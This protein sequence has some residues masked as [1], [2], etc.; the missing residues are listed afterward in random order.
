MLDC[1]KYYALED[2]RAFL[3]PITMADKEN[4][5]SFSIHEPKLWKYSLVQ[6]IG[7]N[8]LHEYLE[9]TIKAKKQGKEYAFIVFDKQ[10]NSY[11]GS[12]R[13]YD[14]QNENLTLQLGYTWY[15][16]AYHGTGLNLHCKYLL[17]SFAFEDLGM[18]RVEFRADANNERSIAAMKKIGCTVEGVLRSNMFKHDGTRRDSIVLSIL[19]TEWKADVKT[20]LFNLMN[21]IEV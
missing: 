13:F 10:T 16:K 12:T 8:G 14:I 15:G 4:L 9:S 19:D 6:P 20:K 1:N 7:E 3:R 18:K 21:S 17:L 2:D 5:L 11:A